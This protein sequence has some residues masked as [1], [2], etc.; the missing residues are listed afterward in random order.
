MLTKMRQ[1]LLQVSS[2]IPMQ[3]KGKFSDYF[4][5]PDAIG[6][7]AKLGFQ[8]GAELGLADRQTRSTVVRAVLNCVWKGIESRT[9]ASTSGEAALFPSW[10]PMSLTSNQ[11]TA[12]G[13]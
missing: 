2:G 7:V 8:G 4:G 9:C 5:N 13:G 10:K 1:Q 12:T 11:L 3:F 6:D